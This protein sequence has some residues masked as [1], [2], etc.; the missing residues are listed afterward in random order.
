[1][2]LLIFVFTK[3]SADTK[4]SVLLLT[5]FA[6]PTE[7]IDHGA[8]IGKLSKYLLCLDISSYESPPQG[9]ERTDR[10]GADILIYKL[11]NKEVRHIMVKI[12]KLKNI[13]VS[14]YIID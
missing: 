13:D 12:M 9:V 14:N 7:L 11:S 2:Y 6:A 3:H 5:A 8:G 1:M 10:W 4:Q